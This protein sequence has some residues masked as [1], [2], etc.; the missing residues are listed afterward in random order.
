MNK[1]RANRKKIAS[2]DDLPAEKWLVAYRKAMY[3][4]PKKA[5]GSVFVRQFY[6]AGYYEAYDIVVSHAERMNLEILWFH[7]KR[8]CEPFFNKNFLE[9]ETICTYCN[10]KFNYTEPLPCTI[11]GCKA[12]LCSKQCLADHCKLRH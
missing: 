2:A 9:L 3:D 4:S 8:S 6:A 5:G 10:K 7:E 1:K 12:E 11:D